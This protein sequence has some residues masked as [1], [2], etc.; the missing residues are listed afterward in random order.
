MSAPPRVVV[1]GSTMVDLI[2]YADRL[3]GPGE[4]LVGR[5]FRLGFG[6]KGANQA[7]MLSRLGA[8]VTFVNCV[9]DDLFGGLTLQNLRESGL[10][11]SR[12]ETQP[13]AST[14]VAS[15]WV[16]PDGTNRIVIVPG[17]NLAVTAG[18]VRRQLAGLD[19]A[20]CVVCQLEI[21][22]EAVA[23]AFRFG[24]RQGATTI[25]NPAPFAPLAPEVLELVD[26]LLPNEVE[27]EQ[28]SGAEPDDEPLMEASGSVGRGVVVTL[29]ERG[30]ASSLDGTVTRLEAP[31]V[32][33]VDTTGA[34]DAFVGGFAYATASGLDLPQALELGNACGALSVTRPGAQSSFPSGEEVRALLP[35]ARA[36][37]RASPA[38][39]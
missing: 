31:H 6:G 9:G 19:R 22:Q 28:L 34:G 3:P 38:G 1:V 27:F 24:R 25:L 17:A 30:A 37:R 26:W 12:V 33:P 2:A 29:G 21:P 4:T 32:Q 23:E 36:G 15:I 18:F 7:V 8:Q 20:D 35:R 5:E 16:E 39:G 10:D 14:G 11:T 13:G